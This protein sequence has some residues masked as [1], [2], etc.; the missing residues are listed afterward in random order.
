MHDSTAFLDGSSSERLILRVASNRL[1]LTGVP[2]NVELKTLGGKV[3]NLSTERVSFCVQSMSTSFTKTMHDVIVVDSLPDVELKH[4][5]VNFPLHDYVKSLPN[6]PC[7][8]KPV[9]LLIG[10]R[11]AD[12]HCM[13]SILRVHDNIFTAETPL[14]RVVFGSCKVSECFESDPNASDANPGLFERNASINYACFT[15]TQLNQQLNHFFGL[16]FSD[17]NLQDEF[18][19]PSRN[20]DRFLEI[21]RSSICKVDGHYQLA[22]PFVRDDVTLPNN[23]SYALKYLLGLLKRINKAGP[24]LFYAI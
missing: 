9:E 18:L 15:K 17:C 7:T 6:L 2:T 24:E 21:I 11:D 19:C 3:T 13:N 23:Y 20:D 10:I 8:N 4:D 12:L 16:E 22:L 14:G 1:K 5:T